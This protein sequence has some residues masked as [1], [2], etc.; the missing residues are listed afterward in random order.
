MVFFLLCKHLTTEMVAMA[1]VAVDKGKSSI[2]FEPNAAD[3]TEATDNHIY[4]AK[5]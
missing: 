2:D 3:G 5:K 1:R 4:D